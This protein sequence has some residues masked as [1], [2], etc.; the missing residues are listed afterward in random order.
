MPKIK[1]LTIVVTLVLAGLVAFLLIRAASGKMVAPWPT[2]ETTS[3]VEPVTNQFGMVIGEKTVTETH[4]SFAGFWMWV[5]AA[6]TLCI[7]SFL[8]R[9]N[10]F[11][12]FAEHLFVGVS[13]AYWMVL[14]FWAVLVPNLFGS[15]APKTVEA[16]LPGIIPDAANASPQFHYLIALVLGLLLLARL[17]EG[18]AVYS[19]WA[20][21][22]IVGTTAGLYFVNYLKSDFMNQVAATIMPLVSVT[23]GDFSLAGTFGALV[24]FVGVMCGLIY[25]FFSTEH[26]GVFGVA[27]R[28]GIWILMISFGASF[29]FTVMGRIALLVGR[30]EFLFGD[31]L[32]LIPS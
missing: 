5:G 20:L 30:M 15:L 8:Y 31:W 28:V 19:R 13:A 4:T 1:P 26:S 17:F 10:P 16:M 27:S 11:Y 32:N 12:R 21:A 9:D 23:N 18:V 7:M 24:I 3:S 2:T 25:F 14:G 22:F 6:L 29:G